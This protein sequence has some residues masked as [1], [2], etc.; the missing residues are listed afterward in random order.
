MAEIS[1][2]PR[3][4]GL[5]LGEGVKSS[6]IQQGLGLELLLSH[7]KRSQFRFFWASD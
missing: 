2:L 7:L 5:S 1:L 6:V 3:V 4:A